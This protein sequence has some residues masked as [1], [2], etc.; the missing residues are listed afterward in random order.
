MIRLK[1][2]FFPQRS[3][4]GVV[5]GLSGNKKTAPAVSEL[6]LTWTLSRGKR[7]VIFT[8]AST[9]DVRKL[10]AWLPVM[11]YWVTL[12]FVAKPR[13]L[14]LNQSDSALNLAPGVRLAAWEAQRCEGEE[15]ITERNRVLLPGR[16]AGTLMSTRHVS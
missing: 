12:L 6:T 11:S 10:S 16:W 1:V 15:L 14:P 4:L 3:A 2:Q 8:C 13:G 5:V 9:H 7:A